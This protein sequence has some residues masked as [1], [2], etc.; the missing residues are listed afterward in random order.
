M[1]IMEPDWYEAHPP[2]GPVQLHTNW[3]EDRWLLVRAEQVI[4]DTKTIDLIAAQAAAEK[5]LSN[6]S[7]QGPQ[8]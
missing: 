5:W 2:Q 1:G 7:K 4:H 3:D 8:Q 6:E